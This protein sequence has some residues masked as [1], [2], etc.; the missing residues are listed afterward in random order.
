MFRNFFFENVF[1]GI[2]Q[3]PIT[4][5]AK[6]LKKTKKQCSWRG[7]C[8]FKLK[9]ENIEEEDTVSSILIMC[10]LWFISM[11]MI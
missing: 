7:I 9:I 11:Y 10:L 3:L 5:T 6:M 1:Q 8:F 4:F 2:W